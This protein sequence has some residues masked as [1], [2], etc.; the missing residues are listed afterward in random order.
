MAQR[1]VTAMRDITSSG[2]DVLYDALRL[3]GGNQRVL[4]HRSRSRVRAAPEV[5][6]DG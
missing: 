3:S 4:L 2:A 1:R 5:H 6:L